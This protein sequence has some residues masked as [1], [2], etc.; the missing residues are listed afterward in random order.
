MNSSEMFREIGYIITDP[1]IIRDKAY[2]MTYKTDGGNN[3]ICFHFKSKEV[4]VKECNNAV[5]IDIAT[6]KAIFKEC[7]ELG[8]LDGLGH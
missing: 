1:L 6:L 2:A 5:T 8:W 7:K 3:L 4:L